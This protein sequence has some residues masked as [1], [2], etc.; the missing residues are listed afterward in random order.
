MES[1]F[2]V[3]GHAAHPILI[4]FPLGLLATSVIFDVLCAATGNP[5]FPVAA[6]WMIA[7]GIIGGLVAAVPGF[8]DWL[9]IPKDTRAK[10]VGLIHAVGNDIV[11]VLFAVSWW[12][13]RDTQ[14]HDPTTV[15]FA[16]S[17]VGLLLALFTGWLGGELVERHAVG[18]HDGAHLDAPHSLSGRPA[19]ERE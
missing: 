10:R 17:V 5:Q 19:R 15:A 6:Y 1:R 7:A 2:K 4:V 14:D 11:L 18:V 12:L 8:V 16:L 9:A 13:R 3:L